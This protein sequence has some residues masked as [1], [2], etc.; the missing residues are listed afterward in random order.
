MNEIQKL[1]RCISSRNAEI[2]ELDAQL[3]SSMSRYESEILELKQEIER[4]EKL[5]QVLK[6]S[7]DNTGACDCSDWIS[8]GTNP[9]TWDKLKE[10]LVCGKISIR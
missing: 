2:R 8:A 10:C 9:N 3:L 7:S 6:E 5:I 4:K 1:Q